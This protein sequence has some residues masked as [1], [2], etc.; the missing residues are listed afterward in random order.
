[1]SPGPSAGDLREL[2]RADRAGAREAI[3]AQLL[4]ADPPARDHTAWAEACEEAGL[5]DLAAREWRLCLEEDP[6][7][8]EAAL[9]LAQLLQ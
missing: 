8:A 2:A 1:M 4:A 6:H 3:R 7:H 9:R 5:L